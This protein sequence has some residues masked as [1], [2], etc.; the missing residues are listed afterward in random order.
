MDSFNISLKTFGNS[1]CIL[2]LY[3]FKKITKYLKNF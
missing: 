2:L 3:L 1:M